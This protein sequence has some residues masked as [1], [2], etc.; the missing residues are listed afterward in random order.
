MV[1]TAILTAIS[2]RSGVFAGVRCRRIPLQVRIFEHWRTAADAVPVTYKQGVSSSSLLAPTIIIA[3]PED[4]L[5]SEKAF[6]SSRN[7][8]GFSSARMLLGTATE[9]VV[10]P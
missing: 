8:H 7:D 10:K 6:L 1:L 3:S 4:S 2:D 5:H 9:D